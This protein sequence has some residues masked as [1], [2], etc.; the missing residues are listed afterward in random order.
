MTETGLEFPDLSRLFKP[1]NVLL[2][3]ASG[4]IGSIGRT[5]FDNL[6]NSDIGGELYLVGPSATHLDA[7]HCYAAVADLPPADIDVALIAVPAESVE[8]VVA[9]CA[10]RDVSFAIVISSGFG[11]MGDN[12]RA[13]Q[14]RLTETARR[15]RM[16]VYGP[17][18][19]GLTNG[20]HRVG[21]NISSSYLKDLVAGPIGLVTQGGGLGRAIVQMSKHATGVGLWG[22]AGNE[23]D[24]ELSDLIAHMADQPEIRAIAIIAEGF[25][26]GARFIAAAERARAAG[27]P[28]VILKVGRSEYGSKAAAS[29]TAA[30]VGSD[31]VNSTVF[32][33]HGVI[34]VSDV[35]ELYETATLALRAADK[36]LGKVVILG[37]SGGANGFASDIL[38]SKGLELAEFGPETVRTLEQMLPSYAVVGNP[39]DLT[40]RVFSQEGLHR[41]SL[42][43]ICGAP[44][45]DTLLIPIP[46]EY[47]ALTA[48]LARDVVAIA[49]QTDRLIVPIWMSTETGEGFDIM[50]RSGILPFRSVGKAVEALRR[51]ADYRRSE[52]LLRQ[53]VLESIPLTPA[54]ATNESFSEVEG[55]RLLSLAGIRIPLEML[56]HSAQQAADFA[57]SLGCKVAIKIVSPDISH[58]TEAGGVALDVGHADAS[59]AFEDVM[60]RAKN[61]APAARL[62]GILVSEMVREGR[63][64]L[65]AVH[66][67]EIFGQVLTIGLGGTE[68]ELIKENLH[69]HLPLREGEIPAALEGTRI[70]TILEGARGLPALDVR[71][72]VATAEALAGLANNLRDTIKELEINPLRV[73]PEGRGAVAL[74]ALAVPIGGYPGQDPAPPQGSAPA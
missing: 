65:V 28:L 66:T 4:K 24:L 13:V 20:N 57:N 39:I 72:L 27:K 17:N 60:S 43:A 74:D 54:M 69:F 11:E 23:C 19:P 38:G 47:G 15:G 64:F 71:A 63:D 26:S 1:R 12:G 53:P 16:R 42:E 7:R 35:D 14:R 67:D 45:T 51:L 34:R 62:E 56:V 59:R 36:R 10:E 41:A 73:L 37:F 68:V 32:R 55:K 40:T 30:M 2:V 25:R 52:Q 8:A 70:A 5:A 46:G 3:G 49:D 33:K 22:S 50:A 29:H 48:Q 31:E 9:D 44:E 6:V 58:K 18:C 21:L 61:Y